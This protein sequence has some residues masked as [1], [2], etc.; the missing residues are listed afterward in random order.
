MILVDTSVWVDI[1]RDKIGKVVSRFRIL[2]QGQLVVLSRFNQLELLQGAKN[3]NEWKMLDEYLSTQLFLE[4][5][6]HTWRQAARI[7]F[8]L[9]RQGMTVRSPIDCCIAQCAIEHNACLLHKDKDFEIMS[10]IRSLK[11]QRFY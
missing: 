9:R 1:F 11:Q 7:F 8:E 2:T 4:A 10:N 6:D 5:S 3:E